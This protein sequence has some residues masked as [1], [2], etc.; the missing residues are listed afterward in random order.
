MPLCI[1][2]HRRFNEGRAPP[3][4]STCPHLVTCLLYHDASS[5]SD[6]THNRHSPQARLCPSLTTSLEYIICAS[7]RL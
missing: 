4:Q 6:V 1:A 2:A 7:R 3:L 5:C